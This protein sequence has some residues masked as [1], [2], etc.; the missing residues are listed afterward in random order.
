[1]SSSGSPVDGDDVGV[2]AGLDR[3]DLVP[4]QQSAS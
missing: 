2:A 1:M 4:L 3:A